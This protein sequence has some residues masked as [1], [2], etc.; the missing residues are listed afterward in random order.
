MLPA[1]TIKLLFQ[2]VLEKHFYLNNR[3]F[4]YSIIDDHFDFGC[5]SN[6]MRN[7]A[8]FLC[9]LLTACKVSN[10]LNK[11]LLRYCIFIFSL[12]CRIASVTSDFSENGAENLQDGDVHVAQIPD[13]EIGYLENHLAH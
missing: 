11:R 3:P 12:P 1:L 7:E 13:F 6:E 2:L 4:V 8:K 9:Y 10:K 5:C